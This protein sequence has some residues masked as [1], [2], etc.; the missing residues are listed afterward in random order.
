MDYNDWYMADYDKRIGMG[1]ELKDTKEDFDPMM[2]AMVLCQ[3][4]FL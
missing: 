3:R 2:E 1:F 4:S